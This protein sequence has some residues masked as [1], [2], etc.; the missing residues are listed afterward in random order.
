M[1]IEQFRRIWWRIWRKRLRWNVEPR[2]CVWRYDE[3]GRSVGNGGIS[4]N[5]RKHHS[6]RKRLGRPAL[7]GRCERLGWI[8]GNGWND[9]RAIGRRERLGWIDGNG[10]ND[11]RAIGW[12]ERLRRE[13]WVWWAH[14]KRWRCDWR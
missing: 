8:D 3:L 1:F 7:I 9:S 10:W 11:S 5:R 12:R 14:R 2:R 4:F 6:G 13:V